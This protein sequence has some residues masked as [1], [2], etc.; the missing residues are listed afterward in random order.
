[1]GFL[2]GAAKAG[3]AAKAIEIVRREASKPQ[4]QAKAR[5]LVQKLRSR[6][7]TTRR[8]TYR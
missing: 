6:G 1:M 7:T 8:G 2:K 4:N 5:E 3:I